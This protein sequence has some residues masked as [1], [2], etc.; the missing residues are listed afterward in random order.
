[1]RAPR[2]PVTGRKTDGKVKLTSREPKLL[3]HA[4]ATAYILQQSEHVTVEDLA[5]VAKHAATISAEFHQ[6]SPLARLK[7]DAEA[8]LALACDYWHGRYRKIPFWSLAPIVF[9]LGYVKNPIGII[10]DFIPGLGKT[11][12]AMLFEACRDIVKADIEAYLA[13][14][15]TSS[16]TRRKPAT[17]KK[18]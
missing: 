13:W 5:D 8:M 2:K 7:V 6:G 17:R 18:R 9:T 11:D 15:K 12:D 3:D 4:Q 10:P 14:C 1:M 16:A